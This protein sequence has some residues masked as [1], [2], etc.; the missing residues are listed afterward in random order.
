ML[1]AEKRV[2]AGGRPPDGG[3]PPTALDAPPDLVPIS[4]CALSGDRATR[5]CPSVETESLPASAMP[6]PCRWHR[7]VHGRV[8]VDWPARYRTW[9][10]ERG[11]L[12]TATRAPAPAPAQVSPPAR[13]PDAALPLQIVN[14][15][16]D[17]TYLRDPTLRTAFQTLPLQAEAA[18]GPRRLLWKVDG[19]PVGSSLSDAALDWPLAAG[20]HRIG[21]EDGRGNSD[22]TRI[23]VK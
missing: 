2:T 11:L 4:V 1:A 21:V 14:P 12:L 19:R 16:R 8:V 22:E 7:R 6:A 3:T 18:G 13:A 23:L 10:K 15:P 17:A 5:D 20:E 9:A